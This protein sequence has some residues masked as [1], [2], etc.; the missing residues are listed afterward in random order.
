[1]SNCIV[2]GCN[3]NMHRIYMIPED[4]KMRDKWLSSFIEKDIW[5]RSD[6]YQ[7]T[8]VCSRHFHESDF[9]QIE[10]ADSRGVLKFSAVPS[11]CIMK[12]RKSKKK[13]K[14]PEKQEEIEMPNISII[15]EEETEVVEVPEDFIPVDYIVKYDDLI[16]NF[17]HRINPSI[18]NHYS[19]ETSPNYL[20]FYQMNFEPTGQVT[21]LNS[22]VITD[23]L[24]MKV[25][26]HNE[27]IT[28]SSSQELPINRKV[29]LYSQLEN[30]L[31]MILNLKSSN[32]RSSVT[33]RNNLAL[34]IYAVEE[35]LKERQ[36]PE[37][38]ETELTVSNITTIKDQLRQ[39]EDRNNKFSPSTILNCFNI[40]GASPD[41]YKFLQSVMYLPE[42]SELK[43]LVTTE[44]G[45]S[46]GKNL[47][48]PNG[49]EQESSDEESDNEFHFHSCK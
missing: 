22:L 18:L 30:L 13:G 20:T 24:D 42:P 4:T 31:E 26:V 43:Q 25:Y 8:G 14:E 44:T 33:F 36:V 2:K 39:I 48:D 49:N 45:G 32:L 9:V 12:P 11:R 6:R 29:T 35:I 7:S 40:H 41:A 47:K 19:T 10:G 46:R 34:S 38:E 16:I 27:L 37:N 1:M 28:D 17:H 3:T 5:S 23:E 15:K 21:I